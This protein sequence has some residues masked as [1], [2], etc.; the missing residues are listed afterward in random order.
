MRGKRIRDITN[1]LKSNECPNVE[2]N[3]IVHCGTNDLERNTTNADRNIRNI[4]ADFQGLVDTF[5]KKMP[6]NNILTISSILERDDIDSNTIQT[7]NEWLEFFAS[8]TPRVRFMNNN[9]V[10]NC[11]DAAFSD[12]VHLSAIG[13]SLLC[14]NFINIIRPH[15]NNPSPR[16]NYYR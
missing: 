12:A 2:A 5:L 1:F 10:N 3:L 4:K 9:R 11:G 8:R 6:N 13:T 15:H 14:Q 7:V 16:N